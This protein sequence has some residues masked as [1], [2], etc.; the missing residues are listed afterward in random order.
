MAEMLFYQLGLQ[1]LDQALTTLLQKTLERGQR[2]VVRLGEDER[3]AALDSYLWTFDD[4]SFLPHG[5]ASDEAAARHPIVLTT[6]N[7]NP[8]NA[9]VCFLVHGAEP[10]DCT[11]YQRVVYIFDGRDDTEKQ[12]AREQWRAARDTFDEVTFWQQTERG[13]WEKQG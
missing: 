11:E 10:T 4:G 1:P 8:G 6:G 7:D 3:L 2:A 9:Q 5:L 13:G 12:A